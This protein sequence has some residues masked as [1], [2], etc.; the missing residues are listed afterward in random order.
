M[1]SCAHDKVCFVGFV[2]STMCWGVQGGV[3]MSGMKRF[4]V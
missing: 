4:R 3:F 1:G 2:G